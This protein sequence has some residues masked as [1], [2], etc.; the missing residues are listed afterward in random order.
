MKTKST[1]LTDEELSRILSAAD[2]NEIVFASSLQCYAGQAYASPY[3]ALPHKSPEYNRWWRISNAV[4]HARSN[5][6]L[7]QPLCCAS[8]LKSFAYR[9]RNAGDALRALRNADLV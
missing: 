3:W 8:G 7:T 9:P 5:R 6:D 1:K 4:Q 2:G